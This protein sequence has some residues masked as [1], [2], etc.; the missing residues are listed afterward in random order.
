[1]QNWGF[2]SHNT[3]YIIPEGCSQAAHISL[4]ILILFS[5]NILYFFGKIESGGTEIGLSTPLL[6]LRGDEWGGQNRSNTRSCRED[7]VVLA[8]KMASDADTV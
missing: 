1:M 3:A 2:N 7:G 4:T 8:V 5:G 6:R